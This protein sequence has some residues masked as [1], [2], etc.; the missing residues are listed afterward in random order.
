MAV[1]DQTAATNTAPITIKGVCLDGARR[2]LLC[3]NHRSEWELPDGRSQLG[4]SFP[5]CLTREIDEETGLAATVHA[6]ICA[7]PYE[8]L[9]SRR[10]NVIVYGCEIAQVAPPAVSAEHTRTMFVGRERLAEFAIADGYREAIELW[11]SFSE[12]AR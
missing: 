2:V 12:T 3:R 8:V 11:D 4:E 10:V 7:Y 5:A 1:D 6:L 9:A